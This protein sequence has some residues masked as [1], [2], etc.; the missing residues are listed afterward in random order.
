MNEQAKYEAIKRLSES[1]GNKK[2]VALKLGC[3]LRHV[4]RMLK[5]YQENGK[6]YF[7]H[8]NK[9]KKPVCALSDELKERILL[10][11]QNKYYDA[12]HY[13]FTQLLS[14][15]EDIHVSAGTVR[16]LL[17][18]NNIL[19]PKA[20]ART[21]K[22]LTAELRE[23][24]SKTKSK[25]EQKLLQEAILTIEDSHPTRERC[26]FAGEMLQMDASVHNWFGDKKTQLHAA[27]DDSTGMIVGAYFDTQETLN[28]YYHVC[29]QILENYGIPYMFYTDRRT[30]FEYKRKHSSHTQKDTFTQ[31]AYACK[32][33]GVELK[34]TSIPQ[35]KGRIERLFGTLQS[36]L[37]IEMRLAGVQTMEQA[38]EF[39]DSYIKEFNAQFAL[40]LN[41]TTS[42]FEEQPD[43]EKIDLILS[44]ISTRTIDAGHSIRYNNHKYR[45][46]DAS[47]LRCDFRK[48]SKVLVI[49]TFSGRLFCSLHDQIY[50][51][52]EIAQH[53]ET[54]LYFS[55]E[56]EIEAAKKAKDRYIPPMNHPWRKDNFM[57]HVFAMTG[58]ELEWVS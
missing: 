4:N 16:K 27:I 51:L 32:Q 37:P 25:K 55:T 45:L 44:V 12:N 24:K 50:A 3:T 21:R 6:A 43:K 39:L 49:Q 2:A 22:K 17:Y 9:G 5:G 20:W 15:H 40:P 52:E 42:V 11:H 7:S 19:S 8:G 14:K 28:G 58:K 36:R 38:N 34:T 33:L 53:E 23:K 56:K 29:K 26:A 57:K 41:T 31:F 46:L 10:L 54:S 30:V 1:G 18:D 48:G 35:A 47:G 13:H